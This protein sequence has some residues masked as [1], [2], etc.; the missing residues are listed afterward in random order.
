L[1]HNSIWNRRT[2]IGSMPFNAGADS[3]TL[4]TLVLNECFL[5]EIALRRKKIEKVLLFEGGT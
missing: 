5:T 2:I 3:G 4:A 1:L